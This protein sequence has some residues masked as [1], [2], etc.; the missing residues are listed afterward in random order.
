MDIQVVRKKEARS[1]MEGP[2]HCREYLKTDKITFGSSSLTECATAT[3]VR[4]V[5]SC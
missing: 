1:F 5:R 3:V 2:E 4:E